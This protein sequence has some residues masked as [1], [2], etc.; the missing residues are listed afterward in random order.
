M[1]KW[2]MCLLAAG[3]CF[4]AS[5]TTASA[6][7][8]SE[9]EAGT[10]NP[11]ELTIDYYAGKADAAVFDAKMCMFG[12]PAANMGDHVSAR[13]IFARCSKEGVLGAMPWMAWTEENGYDRPGDPAR[14]VDWDRKA[15]EAGYSIGQFNYGLDLLRG[16]GVRRDEI[17]GRAYVDRAAK[18]GDSSA[19]ELAAGGYDPEVV[20]PDADKERYRQPLY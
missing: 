9:D 17:L 8:K 4:W 6:S 10:L 14:A 7:E 15:A 16:H 19:A 13:R 20:T 18:Q 1:Q 3:A 12:Y 5:A 2:R 11:Q